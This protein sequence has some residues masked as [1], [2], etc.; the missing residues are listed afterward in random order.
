M[1]SPAFAATVSLTPNY[2]PKLSSFQM[3]QGLILEVE[4]VGVNL[5]NMSAATPAPPNGIG[6]RWFAPHQDGKVTNLSFVE[7]HAGR[8]N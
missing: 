1:Y 6:V 5:R 4:A 7:G 2:A 3:P 8:F